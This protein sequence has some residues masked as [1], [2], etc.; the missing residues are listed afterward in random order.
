M[1]RIVF[2][3]LSFAVTPT[4]ASAVYYPTRKAGLWELT[5][6]MAAGRTM[7]MSQCTDPSIDKDMIANANPSMQQACT[8]S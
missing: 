4:I 7:T 6:T 2:A 8:R 5:M 1:R 3:A